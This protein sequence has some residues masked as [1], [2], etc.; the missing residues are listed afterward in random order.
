M[1]QGRRGHVASL[2]SESMERMAPLTAEDIM[3][4]LWTLKRVKQ[5]FKLDERNKL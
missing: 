3:L 5:F 2:T 1:I 4:L